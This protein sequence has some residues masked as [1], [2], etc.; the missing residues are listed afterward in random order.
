MESECKKIFGGSEPKI[1]SCL[2][3]V[4][5]TSS[6]FKKLLQVCFVSKKK[7]KIY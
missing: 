5:E 1:T 3:E 6:N 4:T 2:D 7:K